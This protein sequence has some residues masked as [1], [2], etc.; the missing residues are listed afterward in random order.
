MEKE[1]ALGPDLKGVISDAA[2]LLRDGW[3]R[4]IERERERAREREERA[5]KREEASDSDE[6]SRDSEREREEATN[7]GTP[8]KRPEELLIPLLPRT[9]R[10]LN[11][12]FNRLATLA[13]ECQDSKAKA[14]AKE[15][16]ATSFGIEKELVLP[17][18]AAIV[19]T[20]EKVLELGLWEAV[21]RDPDGVFSELS[22]S[23]DRESKAETHEN[24]PFDRLKAPWLEGRAEFYARDALKALTKFWRI[25][26][27]AQA[28][29]AL[30]LLSVN[31]DAERDWRDFGG[32]SWSEAFDWRRFIRGDRAT[33]EEL[34]KLTQDS[35]VRQDIERIRTGTA[36]FPRAPL[37]LLAWLG[38]YT[39]TRDLEIH[40][41]FEGRH[42]GFRAESSEIKR[43][44]REL[45]ILKRVELNLRGLAEGSE[46]LPDDALVVIDIRREVHL[47]AEMI[48]LYAENAAQIVPA[49]RFKL[50]SSVGFR[51]IPE[52]IVD[53][54]GDILWLFRELGKTRGVKCFHVAFA[55]SAPLAFFVGR[56]L[57]AFRPVKLYEYDP[58]G[59]C[60]RYVTGLG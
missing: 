22:W 2:E 24:P 13:E 7:L 43:E 28:L 53:L 15:K 4:E 9:W 44:I 10:A 57:H 32:K 23:F 18:L 12:T 33:A 59:P 20:D 46:Q 16:Y 54:L 55:T 42:E 14:K 17:L 47:G 30:N 29:R 35:D 25:A 8:W 56:E 48:P 45:G 11:R 60:Y 3:K 40:N 1:P 27:S 34:R 5:R 50:A 58:S 52:N 6:H 36:L 39:R 31:G 21:D 26:R 49:H 38:W 51:V 19:A 37:S 41:L